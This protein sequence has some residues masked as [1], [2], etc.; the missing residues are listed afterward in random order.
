[1]NILINRAAKITLAVDGENR[2]IQ[3]LSKTVGDVLNAENIEL[4]PQDQ[5]NPALDTLL[6]NDMEI[7]ITRIKYEEI[8]EEEDIDFKEIEQKDSQ[9]DWGTKEVSQKGEKGVRT[10]VYKVHY[11]NGKEVSS[12]KLSTKITKAPI[13]QITKIG[14]KLK[15]GKSDSG[16]A[17][18]YDADLDECASRDFPP[19]RWLRVTNLINGKQVFV[20][21]AGYGPQKGTGKIIDLDNKSFKQ[22]AP[23]GQGV[24]KVKVEE[25]L[26]KGFSPKKN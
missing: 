20:K 8:S 21:V 17:S 26:N 22:I 1:M 18:W 19:G 10:T 2:E 6:Q 11:E 7:A 3:T 24:V 13:T 16:I 4:A 23:L 25:V 15:I 9:V 12:A 5:V 14:T